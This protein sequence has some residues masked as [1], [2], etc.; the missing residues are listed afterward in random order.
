MEGGVVDQKFG[1]TA[2]DDVGVVVVCA[3]FAHSG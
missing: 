1:R 2:V 3:E